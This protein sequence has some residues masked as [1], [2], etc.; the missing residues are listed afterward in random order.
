[1]KTHNRF[2]FALLLILAS[3]LATAALAPGTGG[4][5]FGSA[6]FT[7]SQ[8]IVVGPHSTW[9]ECNEAFQTSL[10]IRVNDWGYTVESI[11]PCSYTPPFSAGHVGYETAYAVDS[12]DP[13]TSL[14]HVEAII[15]KI[16][17]LREQ[18]RITEYENALQRI[19]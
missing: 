8:G 18:Y 13:G 6:W 10:D 15:N 7:N 1:M 2:I 5:Y 3:S 9:W 14:G 17:L 4:G 16:A 12:S 19:K 11:S